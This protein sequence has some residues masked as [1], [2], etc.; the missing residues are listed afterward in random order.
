MNE[1]QITKPNT[2]PN[3]SDQLH[4]P[5]STLNSDWPDCL[6]LTTW[7]SYHM[8]SFQLH[9]CLTSLPRRTAIPLF[10]NHN[11][12]ACQ[13]TWG[14]QE[15]TQNPCQQSLYNRKWL[16]R[17]SPWYSEQTKRQA[18]ILIK[19]DLLWMGKRKR[20]NKKNRLNRCSERSDSN[21]HLWLSQM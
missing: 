11:M 9:T 19:G 6:N 17:D 21:W 8:V 3:A 15:R 5:G 13:S 7:F 14:H 18:C 16:P 20:K 2:R 10:T 1:L 4:I 12:T